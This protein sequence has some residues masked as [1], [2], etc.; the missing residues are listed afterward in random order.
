MRVSLPVRAPRLPSVRE[1]TARAD[2]DRELVA[3][4]EQ[5]ADLIELRGPGA[6]DTVDQAE[7]ERAAVDGIITRLQIARARLNDR[8]GL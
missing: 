4:A 8:A 6:L 2:A 3:A 5:M 7:R 1:R